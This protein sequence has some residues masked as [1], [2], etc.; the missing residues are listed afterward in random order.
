MMS[1]PETK[2]IYS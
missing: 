1:G 2:E